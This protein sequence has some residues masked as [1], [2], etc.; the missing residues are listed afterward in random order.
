MPDFY[1]DDIFIDE[2]VAEFGSPDGLHVLD[3]RTDDGEEI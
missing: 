3:E 1:G 2:F